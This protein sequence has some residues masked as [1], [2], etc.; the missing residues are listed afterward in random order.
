MSG[1]QYIDH[2]YQ[3]HIQQKAQSLASYLTSN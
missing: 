2:L 3:S 1:S